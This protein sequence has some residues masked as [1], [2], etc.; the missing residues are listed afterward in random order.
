MKTTLT[1]LFLAA[2]A[3]IIYNRQRI[4][5]RDPLAT[6]YRND[7]PQAGAEVF[8]N[9]SNDVLLEQGNDPD[10]THIL[11]QHWN[12]R[13]GTPERL[14]CLRWTACLTDTEEASTIPVLG[15]GKGKYDPKVVM[16][17]REVTYLDGDGT[18]VRIELR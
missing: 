17:S 5:V 7:I 1:I 16:T 3:L 18:T 9:Y 4:Y 10:I 8:I 12:R 6:V 15:S 2:L 13:P 11:I 14:S